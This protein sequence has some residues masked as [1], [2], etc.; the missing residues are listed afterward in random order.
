MTKQQLQRLK[1]LAPLVQEYIVLLQLGISDKGLLLS[2]PEAARILGTDRSTVELL[3]N[4]PDLPRMVV[5][6]S[7]QVRIP[8]NGLLAFVNKTSKAWF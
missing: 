8:V 5:G 2:I 6:R 7:K 4:N 3:L 1:N